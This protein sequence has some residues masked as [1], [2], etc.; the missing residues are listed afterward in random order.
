M[1]GDHHGLSLAGEAQIVAEATFQF[2][3]ADEGLGHQG[4]PEER[5]M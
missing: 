2:A 1:V 3:D 5:S 4:L